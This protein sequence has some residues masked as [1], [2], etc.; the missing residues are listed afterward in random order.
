[1]KKRYDEDDYDDE[2]SGS[3]GSQLRDSAPIPA[4]DKFDFIFAAVLGAISVALLS[5]WAFP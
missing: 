2:D 5:L 3:D 1:M 4:L